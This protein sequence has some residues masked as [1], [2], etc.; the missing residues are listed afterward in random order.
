VTDAELELLDQVESWGA[1]ERMKS[2]HYA[3]SLRRAFRS[4]REARGSTVSLN[5]YV[6]GLVVVRA[7]PK[8]TT[9]T[10]NVYDGL[11]DPSALP[12]PSESLQAIDRTAVFGGASDRVRLN[13]LGNALFPA[14][15]A[16]DAAAENHAPT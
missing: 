12:L 3:S 7:Y 11:V 4:I 2:E 10:F 5:V 14:A 9:P 1:V 8:R 15:E 13:A 6:T 16:D